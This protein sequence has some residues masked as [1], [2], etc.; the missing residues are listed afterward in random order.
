MIGASPLYI[1]L[2]R[3]FVDKNQQIFRISDFRGFPN[4]EM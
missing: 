3:I 2:F 1:H 4:K